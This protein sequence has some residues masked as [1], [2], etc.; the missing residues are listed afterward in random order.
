[1]EHPMDFTPTPEQLDCIAAARD[2]T[3]NLAIT[4]LAGAAKTSTLILMAEALPR[5]SILALAF[6]KKIATEMKER[7]PSHCDSKTLNGLGLGV[8]CEKLGKRRIPLD[9]SKVY[10]LLTEDVSK[11]DPDTT[12]R[13]YES[14]S[15]LMRTIYF[16]KTCG[17]VPS[18]YERSHLGLMDDSDFF[19]HLPEVLEDWEEQLVKRVMLASIHEGFEGT[20]DFNDQ[21][22]LPT[23]FFCSFPYYEVIMVDEAQD[24][25]ALNH[26]MLAKLAKRSRVI[27]VGDPC[28]A[29]YGFR[30]AHE[31]SMNALKHE[32][33]MRELFLT[34]SFRC[35]IAVVEE[36]R[37]RA[38]AMQF[39]AWAKEGRVQVLPDWGPDTL[40][41]GDV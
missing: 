38:P 17:Y 25:S 29:I 1:M 10:R 31:D 35:P 11:L 23:V 5:Q 34:V 16:A 26:A 2:T 15:D 12:S 6:N 39:P 19:A 24:L 33:K 18:S 8:W 9:A 21:I 28:Q 3:D 36:A 32:F 4:A 14:F 13:A 30:G 20:I 40:Q 27:A 22:Y 7:L 41:D 37:W